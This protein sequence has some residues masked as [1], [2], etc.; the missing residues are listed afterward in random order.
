MFMTSRV[1][2]I[3]PAL[4]SICMALGACALSCGVAAEEASAPLAVSLDSGRVLGRAVVAQGPARSWQGMPYAAP[5]VGELR[6]RAPRPAAAWQGIRTAAAP[7][8]VCAQP[9]KDAAGKFL[10]VGSEDCLT[11]NVFAPAGAP[12]RPL[13][14]MFWIHGGGQMYGT[15]AEFDAS[16]LA[17]RAEVVVVTINYRLGP[18]GWFHHPAIT[19]ADGSTTGQFALEDM[20]AALGWVRRNIAAFG[21]DPGNVTL[22]G[23]SAGGQNI[24]ALVLA[25]RAHGLFHKAIA[26]SGGFWNMSLAQAVNYRDDPVPGTPMSA[27]EMVDRLLMAGGKAADAKAARRVQASEA[28]AALARWLRE[29]PAS[30]VLEP[31]VREHADYDMPSVVYDGVLIP[32]GDHRSLL[33]SGRYNIVPMIVGGN[34]DEQKLY[35]SSDPAQVA[36]AAGRMQIRDRGRY[37]ALNRFYSDW[38]NFMDTDDLVPRLRAPVYA[39]RFDWDD[40]STSPSDMKS[41][42]GAAHGLELAFV[43][44]RFSYGFVH[45]DVPSPDQAAG[46]EASEHRWLFNEANRSSRERVSAA[47]MSYWGEFAHTGNPGTGRRGELPAWR[48][49]AE[50]RQ[51]LIFDNDGVHSEGGL[52]DGPAL[53]EALWADP[54][55]SAE[56]KCAIFLDDTMF[57]AYPLEGLAAHRC[58]Y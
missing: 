29:L 6:W 38:W 53:L 48:P 11:L 39:Y 34:R 44:G 25:P 24:Y 10:V 7:G 35:L 43:F 21:G 40:E 14:V 27:R 32:E 23:E 31:Y 8:P 2:T 30:A 52:I 15:G 42:F 4:L 57:P 33:A 16:N 58:R 28:P 18:F 20:I 19:R 9:G 37:A 54:H 3:R 5:P 50:S 41:I 46:D 1:S 51:K 17:A 55:L 36:E 22:F 47:M 12:R 45:D 26:Q 13:P 56:Q 49:W